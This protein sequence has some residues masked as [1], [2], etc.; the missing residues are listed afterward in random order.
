[1][2]EFELQM[3]EYGGYL[4]RLYRQAQAGEDC[5]YCCVRWDNSKGECRLG[6]CKDKRIME[7]FKKEIEDERG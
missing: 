3:K 7:K 4:A 1:M 5:C 6:G 2:N